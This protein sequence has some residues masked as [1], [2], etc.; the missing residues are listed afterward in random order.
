MNYTVKV[1]DLYDGFMLTEK[2]HE[3]M[4]AVKLLE[5]DGNTATTQS[6]DV[7][8]EGK[9][10]ERYFVVTLVDALSLIHI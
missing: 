5:N 10:T 7:V 6:V 4:N 9:G 1:D 3:L 8:K 2:G